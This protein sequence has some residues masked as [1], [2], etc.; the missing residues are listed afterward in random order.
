MSTS[1]M[2]SNDSSDSD[3]SGSSTSS[4]GS[5]SLSSGSSG[6]QSSSNA[7]RMD[8]G[9]DNS[10][11]DSESSDEEEE[12][13]ASEEESDEAEAEVV[14]AE[15]G[16][17]PPTIWVEQMATGMLDDNTRSEPVCDVFDKEERQD[18]NI[19]IRAGMEVYFTRR[20]LGVEA[21]D[22]ISATPTPAGCRDRKLATDLGMA[23]IQ[24]RML[25]VARKLVVPTLREG[26]KQSQQKGVE[27]CG[28]SD[29]KDEKAT[30]VL[31]SF[32]C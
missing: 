6:S 10:E 11:L 2:T 8:Q 12:T 16:V 19:R 9:D 31:S 22:N 23:M 7:N 25:E 21:S 17:K 29:Q 3:G 26:N 30:P 32:E 24:R 4:D 27:A 1:S 14:D 5:G 18:A 28:S 15:V 13:D 20:S